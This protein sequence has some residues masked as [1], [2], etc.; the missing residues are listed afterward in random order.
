MV[1]RKKNSPAAPIA[2]VATAPVATPKVETTAQPG[3]PVVSRVGF[4]G[5]RAPETISAVDLQN[6]LRRLD[7]SAL[8]VYYTGGTYRARKASLRSNALAVLNGTPKTPITL[9]D[10]LAKAARAQG[11]EVGYDPNVVKGG[12]AL[13]QG[14]KPAVYLYVEKMADGSFRAVKDIPTPDPTFSA[15]G[16][17][18]GDTVLQAPAAQAPKPKKAV[19]AQAAA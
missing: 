7:N 19:K 2:P 18:A 9:S 14:A 1:S 4:R 5:F 6:V 11:G 16:F 12:L 13:H 15:T 10:F 8:Y 17:K 3:A